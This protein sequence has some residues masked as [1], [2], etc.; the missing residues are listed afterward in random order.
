M[1]QN[2]FLTKLTAIFSTEILLF[3]F[4]ATVTV[5]AGFKS[6]VVKQDQLSSF[7]DSVQQSIQPLFASKNVQM[8]RSNAQIE[9]KPEEIVSGV[10]DEHN[11]Q[12]RSG[13]VNTPAASAT[14]TPTIKMIK[15]YLLE[16][17]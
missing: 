11:K 17:Q 6:G 2:K 8:T 9:T 12:E 3:I 4:I 13:Q 16:K 10:S 15:V 1:N 14:P 7:Y 5:Y